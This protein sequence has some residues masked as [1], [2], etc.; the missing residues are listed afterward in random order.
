MLSV[1]AVRDRL[2]NQRDEKSISILPHVRGFRMASLNINQLTTHI[3]ELRILLANNDIDIISINETKLNE[4]IRDHEVHI[5]GY[6]VIRRDRLKKCGGG[7]CFY[8][9]NS[10]NFTVRNDLHM[11][12]IENLCLEVHK[13]NSKSFVIV[14]WYRPPNSP[15]GIFSPFESLI[16]KLDS[17]NVEFF[18]LGDMNCDMITT[19]YDNDTSKLRSIADVYGLEQ[20]ISEPT[21][22]TPTSST[23][24]DL[25]YT[26]CSDKI[27]CS[28]VCHIGISDHSMVYV[29]GKLA[30]NG[31]SNGHNSITYRNFRNFDRQSFRHDILS[32][33]WDNV[34]ESSNPNEMWEQWKCTFLAIADKHAPLKTMRVRSRSSPWITSE[35]KDLMHNRDILKIKASKTNDPTDWA[36]FKKQRNTVNKQIRS[37]K[38]VYYQNSFNKHTSNCRKTWQTINEL[39]SRKSGK[40]S[41][42]SLKVNGL[43]ITNSLELSNE[44]NNHFANIG[45]KLASEINCDSGSYQRYLTVTDKRFKL[46]PTNP[47][48]VFSLLNKLDKSK[49]TGLDKISARI[50]RECADLICVPICDIF[51]QSIS[52]G[53]FPDD[54]K[55]ARVTPLY[56]QG[57]RGDVN[58]Y[59]PISV[60]PIVA[61]VF[62]R[63]VYEQLYAYLEEH[64]ILCQN[65]S[66][67]RANHSTVTALLEATDSWAYNIDNGK[68]NGVIFLDL[69]KAFDTVD[70]QILLSKLS[71][72]GI[73]GKSFKWFQSY[74]ENCTQKCSVNGSLSN[75][76]S[77]TCGVPQGTILG[78]LLFLLY[79][80]DLPNCL[81]NCKPRMY[82]DDTHLTYASS[83]LENLQFCLNEDLANV[84]D[85]LQANKLTLNMT[86]TEFMLIGSRQRLNTLTTSP[87]IRMNS[88]QVS[89]VSATKSLGVMIDDKLDWHDHIEKLTKKIA[90]GIGALK[91]IRHL[92]PAS[93]LH[94]I[95]Q[96]L[97]KP[98]FDYCDI[99]WGNCGKTLRDK[100]QKLQNRAAR[101]LTFSNYDA[102]TTELLEFLGWKNLARQQEIHKATMMF[103]CLHGL[104]PEYLCSKFTWRDPAYNLRDSENK[105]N[106]PLPRTN[107]YRNSF[108]YNGATLWNSLPC[109]IRN[110][111]SLGVFK[112][113]INDI[114]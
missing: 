10:I 22:I 96:A 109:D 70:H 18:V 92:I 112:R 87:I 60:I 64:D 4:S 101:V 84:F 39:T 53:I 88:T 68:I 69:K 5:P 76:C 43:T 12:A 89:K 34:Y 33:C 25:I 38:Q 103:R 6:E 57:D 8:V 50:V 71:Y 41:V 16:G 66:G 44:F 77:L 58:N 40:P 24:I 47:N 90:S 82:A 114:L 79:I 46:Q 11:D 99:V 72:Y 20:L 14:T 93:T 81:S 36:L 95:Y 30:L 86:K 97:I 7:V 52:Q 19:R 78:P 110:I 104:A 55:Y 15:I 37:A 51:N 62:E 91:R 80:N 54:W 102:D 108:S 17:E 113:K 73:H 74:L 23:L 59:R 13:P 26:N 61:K 28:G 67:F 98:H 107:Y 100:L 27:A 3:D 111:E 32:Q 21:R 35:L 75:S 1:N 29:Y 105:L 106:V 85:W 56:K 45:P 94:L 49:A 63:I 48:K 83:N 2:S 9:K 42:A 31:M 65:Q